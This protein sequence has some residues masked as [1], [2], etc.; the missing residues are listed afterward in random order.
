MGS[1]FGEGSPGV[2]S[3]GSEPSSVLTHRA[4]LGKA[5]SLSGPHF[6]SLSLR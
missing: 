4:H 1:A 6:L 3:P 5:F 2:C